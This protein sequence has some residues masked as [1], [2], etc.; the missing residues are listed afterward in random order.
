MKRRPIVQRLWV[1]AEGHA[2]IQDETGHRLTDGTALELNYTLQPG[3]VLSGQVHPLAEGLSHAVRFRDSERITVLR[4][5]GEDFNQIYVTPP[6]G[7]FVLYVP[8]GEYT[9]SV[10]VKH[11]VVAKSGTTDIVLKGEVTPVS[12]ADAARRVRRPLG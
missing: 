11:E 9:I 10:G 3:E 5:R 7:R 6:D 1:E 2:R 12:Q 8:A 4:V